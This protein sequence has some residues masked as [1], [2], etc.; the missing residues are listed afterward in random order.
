MADVFISY[1]RV[2]CVF[3]RGLH[4]FL[5]DAGRDVWVDWEDL[6][7][8]AEWER[9]IYDSIDA[10]ESFVFVVSTASLVSE[11][12]AA[13]LRHAQAHGKRIVP[14][15]CEA[16]DPDAASPCLRELNWIWCRAGDDRD[17]AFANLSDA[18]DC[19]LEWARAHTRLLARALEWEACQDDS[20]LLR[21]RAL[22]R[23]EQAVAA[24]AA[25]EPT[26]TELQRQYLHASRD[27]ASSRRWVMLGGVL[28]ALFASRALGHL[29][30]P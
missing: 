24:N 1:S 12:C 16:V 6:P 5:S 4:A 8:A 30:A 28:L 15:A 9:D 29:D 25:K 27:A 2:D 23:A 18:L 22:A 7:P 20:L 14:I 13:E 19:D 10:A 21:G 3:V 26:P 11:H 17:A